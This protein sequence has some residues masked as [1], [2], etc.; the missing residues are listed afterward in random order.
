MKKFKKVILAFSVLILF[1]GIA[2]AISV[3]RPLSFSDIKITVESTES[4]SK[5]SF[6]AAKRQ[7]DEGNVSFKNKK[8]DFSSDDISDYC[9]VHI[10]LTAKN[11]SLVHSRINYFYPVSAN[12]FVICGNIAEK[13]PKIESRSQNEVR[14][15]FTILRNGRTD[16]EI[17][18]E[19]SK[20]RYSV[21]Y[22]V[23]RAGHKIDG[24]NASF[25]PR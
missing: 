4:E 5:Q 3:L 10:N 7:Y 9:Y 19:M 25:K 14:H 8:C 18:N 23:F 15:T 21:N 12:D 24:L 2:F 22:D 17:I 6:D 20:M 16:E 13:S 1:I 11:N